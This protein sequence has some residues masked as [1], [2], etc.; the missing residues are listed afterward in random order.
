MK[1]ALHSACMT[2]TCYRCNGVTDTPAHCKTPT[3]LHWCWARSMSGFSVK[4]RICARLRSWARTR[5]ACR[6]VRVP[7]LPSGHPMPAGSA[8]SAIST[9]GMVGATRCVC[10][11][12]AVSG[13]CFCPMLPAV[14]ST[15]S[16]S[17]PKMAK[18]CRPALTLMRCKPSCAQPPPARSA[19]CRPRWQLHNSAGRP[20]R[21]MP[22]SAFTKSTSGRGAASPRTATAG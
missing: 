10:A 8:L 4:A 22:P 17:V 21:W 11:A 14:H 20:T 5:P 7:V 12:N 3:A 2:P 16:K 6:G 18:S 9:S 13:S 15:N 19:S 1:A